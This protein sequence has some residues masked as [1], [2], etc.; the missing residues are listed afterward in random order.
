MCPVIDNIRYTDYGFDPVSTHLRGGFDWRLDFFWEMITVKDRAKRLRDPTVP[1]PT[2]AI[3]GGLFAIKRE[4]LL[5]LG[6]YDEKMEIWGG[7]NIEISLRMWLCGGEMEIVPCSKVGHIYK[8]RNVYSYPKGVEKTRLCNFKRVARSWLDQFEVL[9]NFTLSSAKLKQ[10]CG[11]VSYVQEI[12]K[13]LECK[14]FQWYLENVYPELMIPAEGDFAFGQ[15]LARPYGNS[16]T[17]CLDSVAKGADDGLLG[18]NGCLLTYNPQ[19]HRYTGDGQIIMG[20]FCYSTDNLKPGSSVRCNVCSSDDSTQ[21]WTRVRPP[22]KK[23]SDLS[24][25]FLKNKAS[26]LCLDVSQNESPKGVIVSKCDEES[27]DQRFMFQ[28]QIVKA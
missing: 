25:Y 16:F 22:A 8:D 23:D 21:V 17:K 19:T 20:D 7:E 28:Y 24:G 13:R 27:R 15:L 3:A 5:E 18:I 12:K 4:W 26:G 11:D 2:P 9:Y 6:V 14:P 10:D 1:V